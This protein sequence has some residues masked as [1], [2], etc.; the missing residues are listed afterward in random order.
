ME[1]MNENGKVPSRVEAFVAL[2]K[3]FRWFEI[4]KECNSM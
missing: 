2:E 1:T 3:W 4:E